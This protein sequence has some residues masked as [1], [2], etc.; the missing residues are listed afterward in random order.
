MV[1]IRAAKVAK[2]QDFIPDQEIIGETS[3]DVLV[4]GWGGTFG[5]LISAV[6][7]LQQQ[8][9][10]ISLAHFNYINPLPKNTGEIFKNFKR[11]V[12]CELNLGQFADYL[13]MKFNNVLFEQYNKIQGLPFT[14][15][16]LKEHFEQLLSE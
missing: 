16:E 9:K 11:T 2:V 5:H 4:I 15:I 13:R 14:V 7:E 1:K 8:G 6:E 3:G 10:K 12:V